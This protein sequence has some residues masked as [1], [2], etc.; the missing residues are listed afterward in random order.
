MVGIVGMLGKVGMIH[1]VH[2]GLYHLLAITPERMVRWRTVRSLRNHLG[3]GYFLMT[4]QLE[5]EILLLTRM[6]KT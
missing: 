1:M 5:V 4:K 2:C 3:Q 6:A